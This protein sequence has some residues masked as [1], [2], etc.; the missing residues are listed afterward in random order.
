MKS[1]ADN[2]RCV[3][4]TSQGM[5]PRACMARRDCLSSLGARD[6]HTTLKSSTDDGVYETTDD[7]RL[8]DEKT[9]AGEVMLSGER[10]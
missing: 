9:D 6:W 4:T 1:A 7:W 3:R 10:A 8:R 5:A 2:G